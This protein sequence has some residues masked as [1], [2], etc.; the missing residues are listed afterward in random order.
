MSSLG[1]AGG[2]SAGQGHQGEKDEIQPVP[3]AQAGGRVSGVLLPGS[4]SGSELVLSGWPPVFV[5]RR[6]RMAVRVAVA[7]DQWLGNSWGAVRGPAD[8]AR[9]ELDAR[10]RPYVGPVARADRVSDGAL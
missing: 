7:D 8:R 2:A 5:A 1:L 6:Y 4:G 9:R 3:E 10:R